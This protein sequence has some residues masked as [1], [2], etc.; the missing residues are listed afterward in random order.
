MQ[1]FM[2]SMIT[3]GIFPFLLLS[4]SREQLCNQSEQTRMGDILAIHG[5][6]TL[7]LGKTTVLVIEVAAND[8]ICTKRAEGF[9][10]GVTSMDYVQIGARL[11]YTSGKGDDCDCAGTNTVRTL[12]YFTP[13]KAG[14]YIFG[15]KVADAT[16]GG[17]PP[18][19]SNNYH[20]VVR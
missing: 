13:N 3:I 17:N 8:S 15:S 18:A 9:I 12:I 4:C 14:N 11:V 1:L 10:L 20:V 2:K 5:P 16:T 19:D 6:D 7:S